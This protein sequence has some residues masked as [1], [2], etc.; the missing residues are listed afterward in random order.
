M[1]GLQGCGERGH[2]NKRSLSP[3]E[4]SKLASLDLPGE[5]NH[6]PMEADVHSNADK[7][8]L[9]SNSKFVCHLSVLTLSK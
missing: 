8:Q 3:Y 6:R 9:K 4:P 7:Q 2:N 5:D 1:Q